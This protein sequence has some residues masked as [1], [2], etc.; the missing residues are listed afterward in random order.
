MNSE[1]DCIVV[2]LVE[3]LTLSTIPGLLNQN[4][5]QAAGREHIFFLQQVLSE[6]SFFSVYKIDEVKTSVYLKTTNP[7]VVDE[8]VDFY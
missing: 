5:A 1:I 8:T 4:K 7:S 6:T 3:R 2:R